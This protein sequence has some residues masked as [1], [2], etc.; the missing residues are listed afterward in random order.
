MEDS[1]Y[2]PEIVTGSAATARRR[3][4]PAR[5]IAAATWATST[6]SPYP[7]DAPPEI[8]PYGKREKPQFIITSN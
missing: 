2:V 6:T 8:A 3:R 5:P 4:T 1:D 7:P